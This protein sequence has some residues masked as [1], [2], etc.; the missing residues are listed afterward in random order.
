MK[1]SNL[2]CSAPHRPAAPALWGR[3]ALIFRLRDSPLH[4]P[5]AFPNLQL[6]F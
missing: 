5:P 6:W 4:L 2:P 3:I 1:L